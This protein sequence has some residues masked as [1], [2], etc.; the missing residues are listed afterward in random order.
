MIAISAAVRKET[1]PSGGDPIRVTLAIADTT[2]EVHVPEDF[3][4]ALA[5]DAAAEAFFDKLSNSLQ[6]YQIDNINDA[7]AAGTRQRRVAKPLQDVGR[8]ASGG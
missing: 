4:A 1:G 3:A 8:F 5:A 2:S 7:K 6:R